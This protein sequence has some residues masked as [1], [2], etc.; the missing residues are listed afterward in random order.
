MA[1]IT[2][3]FLSAV[4]ITKN[5][6]KNIRRCL[7]SLQ[8]IADEIIVVDS[9]STD[10]TE[11][12]CKEFQVKFFQKE[13]AGYAQ[14]KNW[15]NEQANSD[16]IFS[17]DAD[18]E[19]PAELKKSI[20]AIKE[21]PGDNFA[22]KMHRLANYCGAWIHHCGWYPDTKPRIFDRRE[23][24][25]EGDFVHETLSRN[26]NKEWQLLKGDLHHYS[27]HSISQH[28]QKI[29]NF[30]TLAAQQ[31]LAKGKKFSLLRLLFAPQFKFF[32]VYIL[33]LGILDGIYGLTIA[34]FMSW[35]H[36]LREMKMYKPHP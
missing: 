36:F 17:I 26:N 15:A 3:I 14:T 24:K 31:R 30:S 28:L 19:V 4:I 2:P 7:E 33:K 5:E 11:N 25:W 8:G 10:N 35:H 29:D 12:I 13:W 22:Y 1:K 9:Y 6:E 18:E 20:L 34:T 27:Y 16:Y 23:C 21:N 32:S